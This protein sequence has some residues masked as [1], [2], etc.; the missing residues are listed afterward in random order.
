M[1]LL[2]LARNFFEAEIIESMQDQ[3][4]EAKERIIKICDSLGL[5]IFTDDQF[6]KYVE[7]IDREANKAYDFET[8]GIEHFKGM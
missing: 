8:D 3:L 5:Q 6:F 1:G 7:K 2:R 4:E